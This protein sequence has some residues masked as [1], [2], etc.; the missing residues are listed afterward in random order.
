MKLSSKTR[1]GL[2]A[3]HFLASG[4][5]KS[6]SAT[7]IEETLNVSA[8]YVEQIMRSLSV[9]GLVKATRGVSGGYYLAKDPSE[10]TVGDIVRALEPIELV[11]CLSKD[12][13]CKCCPSSQ[14]WR[15]LYDGINEVLD[16]MTLKE[17]TEGKV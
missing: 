7:N 2:R 16:G 10:I 6:L 1:Y 4:Y 8:K 13:T 17:M 11:E 15:K 9:A 12:A 14:V 5:P 3:C